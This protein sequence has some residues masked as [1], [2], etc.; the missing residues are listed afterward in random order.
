MDYP[1]IDWEWTALRDKAFAKNPNLNGQSVLGRYIS[2]MHLKQY[3]GCG[4][5]DAAQI[6]EEKEKKLAIMKEQKDASD[7]EI[8]KQFEQ[9]LINESQYKTLISMPEVASSMP[10]A[11][12][13]AG[14]ISAYNE[15]DFIAEEDLPNLAVNLSDE[16][17]VSLAIKWGRLYKPSE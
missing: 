4:W 3:K 15:D 13:P 2:K 1:Y 6:I 7:A 12:V 16:E 11:A 17:K 8:K 10:V 14:A 5:D 9:G